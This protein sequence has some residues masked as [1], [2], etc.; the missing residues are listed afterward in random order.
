MKGIILAGGLATRLYPLTHATNKHLLPVYDQPMVFYPIKT[1]LKAGIDEILIVTGG[2]YAG[3]F[4]RVLKDGKEMGIKHLAY[5]Y[6]EKPGGIADALSLAEDFAD[7][8]PI[9]VI[10]GDN[11][12][13]IDIK[14]QVKSFK[15][16]ATIFLKKV[17]DPERFGVPVFSKPR[18]GVKK[19]ILK[20][21]EKPK[22]PQSEYA[23]TGLYFYD[24]EVFDIISRRWNSRFFI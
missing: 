9:A 19:K 3:D 16:G 14:P 22:V 15:D 23:V 2:P 12:T 17:S 24:N 20:I 5:T 21:E 1:L 11:T 18:K 4:L 10:L 13:D 8:E 7:N 6:Q